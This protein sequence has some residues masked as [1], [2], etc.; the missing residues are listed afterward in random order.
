MLSAQL[1]L[2]MASAKMVVGS[3][4]NLDHVKRAQVTLFRPGTDHRINCAE[5]GSGEQAAALSAHSAPICP[6]AGCNSL[7]TSRLR[8][9]H[10]PST[11]C[12]QSP[13]GRTP[14][15]ASL[16][17]HEQADLLSIRE[18]QGTYTPTLSLSTGWTGNSF[19]YTNIN[20]VV[21]TDSLEGIQPQQLQLLRNSNNVFPF[22]FQRS[23]LTVSAQ[24]SLPIFNGFSR[25]NNLQQA[26]IIKD[27]ARYTTRAQGTL[28]LGHS[29][30]SSSC[31]KTI[32]LREQ[33]ADESREELQLS[34]EKYR[35]GQATFLDVIPPRAT[36]EQALNDAS[37]R[38]M[39]STMRSRRWKAR[40]D[41]PFVSP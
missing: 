10:S 24:I 4:T 3:G 1:Q 20:A 37:M 6:L 16:R 32:A 40:S 36:F 7:R 25:E 19:E 31:Y 21:K 27:N 15:S 5:S 28:M 14:Q 12:W 8:R 30:T 35:V 41:V 34:E 33:N 22:K 18:A 38:S 23:P 17:A 9:L 13:V 26:I 39:I 2:D 11:A 29:V